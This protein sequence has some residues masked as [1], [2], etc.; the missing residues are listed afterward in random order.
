MNSKFLQTVTACLV[1]V[2]VGWLVAS[3][4]PA[5]GELLQNGLISYWP[6]NDGSGTTALDGASGGGVADNGTLRNSPTWTTGMFGA[7]L[8]FNGIDQ[9][10][11]IPASTDMDINTG[12]V[13]LSAWVKLD[14]LPADI[15]GSFSGIFD[16]EPDNYVMYLD[17]G[18]NE[19][20]FKS[21]T[22]TNGAERPGIPA[23]LLDTT[24]WH[25]VMGVFNGSNAS[26][27]IYFDGQLVDVHSAIGLQDG[28]VRAGQVSGIGAQPATASPN[29]AT[30]PFQ[31]G[32][33]DVAVWNRSLGAA[34][35]QY[36]YNGG[37]GHAVGSA[38]P[39]IAPLPPITPV[40]PTAQPVLYYNFNGDLN[41][42]GTGGAA[43]N[44]TLH[45]VTG[46]NDALYTTTPFG[47]GLD[48]RENPIETSSDTDPGDF[49]S[50]DYTLPESGTIAMDVTIDKLYN[51]QTL[52]GN[53]SNANDWEAWIY[54]D[55]RFAARADRAT[56]ILNYNVFL[57]QDQ[58][59][60]HHYA[61]TWERDGNDLNAKI[62]V[63]GEFQGQIV[64]VW[65][66]PGTTFFLAGGTG[67]QL[68]SAIYD[69]VRIYNS[70]LS[71]AEI[72]YLSQ[73]APEVTALQGDYNMDGKVDAGD[74]VVWRNGGSP[75]SSQAGYDLWRAHFG[76]P[77]PGAG[78]GSG[79]T[80]AVVPE[81]ATGSLV[82]LALAVISCVACRTRK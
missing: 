51:F 59:A 54:S 22:A 5:L 77:G 16:S 32:I 26:D 82:L 78:A 30:N 68:G 66:D 29:A 27:R 28:V 18:N 1:F 71:E 48:L 76:E 11:L 41:N 55:G 8:Q 58:L 38:N 19:L 7:G 40:Q 73:N 63:D 33:S 14:Q 60:Q 10:V 24:A 72:L 21:T 9:D 45:D 3:P 23:K 52:W 2:A 80:A 12:G 64:G 35:A 44:A 74:Y 62:Y 6:L 69:E 46:R 65:R 56:A 31:G 17:K 15:A 37:T 39:D 49:L 20:R 67:N 47:Q 43:L 34:E 61:Y 70:A 81:P 79:I 36:L 25:H 53:S 13:T 42:H 57:F 50:V 4:R 75:D